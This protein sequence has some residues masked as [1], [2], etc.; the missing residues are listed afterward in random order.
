MSFNSFLSSILYEGPLW[1]KC[2]QE[3]LKLRQ[4]ARPARQRREDREFLHRSGVEQ[5]S[6][7]QITQRSVVNSLAVSYHCRLPT[8]KLRNAYREQVAQIL[9]AHRKPVPRTDRQIYDNWTPGNIL[10]WLLKNEMYL[11]VTQMS[12]PNLTAINEALLENL[13]VGGP[14]CVGCLKAG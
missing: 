10:N 6:E 4:R 11:Y 12:L 14:K 8:H 2:L 7:E 1:P 3:S 5:L 13:F 9:E